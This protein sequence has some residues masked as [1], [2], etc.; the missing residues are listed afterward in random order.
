M[1]FRNLNALAFT[2]YLNLSG[3]IACI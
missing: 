1:L 2:N 3:L